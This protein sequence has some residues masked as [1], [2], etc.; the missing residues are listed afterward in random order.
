LKFDGIC[1]KVELE[2]RRG[3]ERELEYSGSST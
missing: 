3:E 2:E 1:S